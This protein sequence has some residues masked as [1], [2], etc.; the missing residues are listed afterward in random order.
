MTKMRNF[1]FENGS[2]EFGWPVAHLYCFVAIATRVVFNFKT[3]LIALI[4]LFE[5]FLQILL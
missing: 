1:D 4:S 3:I 2:T 5:R